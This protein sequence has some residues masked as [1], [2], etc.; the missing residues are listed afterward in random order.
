M[1]TVKLTVSGT[2]GLDIANLSNNMIIPV[3]STRLLVRISPG[4]PFVN[5]QMWERI[6]YSADV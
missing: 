1:N 2:F 3:I 5:S 4:N 6:K